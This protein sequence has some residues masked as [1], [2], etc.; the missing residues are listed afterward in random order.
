LIHIFL[1]TNFVKISKNKEN[2]IMSLLGQ[3]AGAAISMADST[4]DPCL[5]CGTS[6]T[7]R[8]ESG[9]ALCEGD[10][11]SLAEEVWSKTD[12]MEIATYTPSGKKAIAPIMVVGTAKGYNTAFSSATFQMKKEAA[13]LNAGGVFGIQYNYKPYVNSA[14]NRVIEIMAY[15]T[16]V[17]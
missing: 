6:T 17:K 15:G 7:K 1:K 4:L 5:V 3:L 10:C 8:H 12:K 9:Y 14:G 11:T 13:A 2:N 16:A